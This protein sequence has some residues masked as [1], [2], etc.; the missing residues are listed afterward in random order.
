MFAGEDFGEL[1]RNY[2][3]DPG[4]AREGGSLG[5]VSPGEMVPAFERVMEDTAVGETSP[6]FET[7]FGWH[8]LRV[9]DQRTTDMSDEYRRLK[10]RQ[11]LHQRR[12]EEELQRW[13]QEKRGESYID[14]RL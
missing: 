4:S 13:L 8:F 7:R 9:E 1:A 10:A 2:S 11:A 12:F 3:D 6:V 5:W 14:T